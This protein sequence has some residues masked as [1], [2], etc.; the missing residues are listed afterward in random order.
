MEYLMTYG[1]A[2]LVVVVVIAVLFSLGVFNGSGSSNLNACVAISGFQCT[3]PILYSSGYLSAN[4]GE[5]GQTIKVTAIGCSANATQPAY[6]TNYNLSLSSGQVQSVQPL[7]SW[8]PANAPIGSSISG[9]LW[10]KYTTSG[11]SPVTQLFG[12]F[13]ANVQ[14]QSAVQTPGSGVA[15]VP[16]TI[17]NFGGPTISGPFQQN[18]TFNPSQSAYSANEASDL[19]NIRFYQGRIELYSWCESG[20]TKSSNPAMFW[21]KL[22]SGIAANTN[23]IINMT[24][25]PTTIDYD[26]NY[27]GESPQLSTFY[28]QF[29]NGANV[30]N[31]YDNFSGTSLSAKWTVVTTGTYDT[32]SQNNG[33]TFTASATPGSI[34][35]NGI[36]IY[37]TSTFPQNSVAEA[38]ISSLPAAIGGIRSSSPGLST[39]NNFAPP[40][41]DDAPSAMMEYSAGI[42]GTVQKSLEQGTS[43]GGSACPGTP[44]AQQLQGAGAVSS[45]VISMAY[46]GSTNTWY[47]NYSSTGSLSSSSPTGNVYL[48]LGIG[49]QGTGG[50]YSISTYWTRVRENPPGGSMPSAFLGTLTH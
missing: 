18:V 33:L 17:T 16:V 28:G 42:S 38:Y 15:Y 36:S 50:T 20:C 29:D 41:A 19:G 13:K 11:G 43:N 7:C 48:Q 12:K 25:L 2:I 26:G 47:S 3:T 8:L 44:C 39:V 6:F 22:P 45:K 27:A 32:K 40:T 24:F 9:Y 10:V 4:F 37:S 35:W 23:V 46:T 30:F 5:I 31:F 14:S 34:A 49:S 1:W 21:V